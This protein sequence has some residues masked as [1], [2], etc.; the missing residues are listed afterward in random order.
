MNI[1][2]FGGTFDPIHWGHLA[3]AEEVRAKL[4]LDEVI[5]IPAGQPWLKAD[6]SISPT[7]HRLK[8]VSLAIAD[9]S[10]FKVSAVEIDRS[11]PSYTVD[12]VTSLRH[13]VG[14][15]A[16][17]FFLLGSDALIDLPQWKEPSRLVQMCRLVTFNRPGAVLPS[18][19]LLEEAIPGVSQHIIVIEVSQIDISATRIRQQVALGASIHQ[20]VPEAVER[21]ILEQ[22]LYTE[23]TGLN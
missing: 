13:D 16:E 17:L 4:E 1:G 8:M 19:T 5:F 6:R 23:T 22:G 12:T 20:L 21:Y 10:Y 7:I 15:K 11:G 18:L 9:K 14:T 3:V 2:L